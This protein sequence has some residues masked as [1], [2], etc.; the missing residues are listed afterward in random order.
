MTVAEDAERGVTRLLSARLRQLGLHDVARL[1]LHRNQTV[2]VSLTARGELRVHEG[3]AEA[4]DRVLQAIVRFVRPG[5]WRITRRAALAVIRSWPVPSTPATVERMVR[6]PRVA[7]G[8]QPIVDRLQARW[9]EF[10][11]LHF[12]DALH[13]IP[14]VISSRMRRMLGELRHDRATGRALRITL[15]RRLLRRHPWAEVE[16]TLLHEMVHQWQAET[17]QPVGHG[18]GFRRKA[19]EVGVTP[20][21]VAGGQG[22]V[23]AA[24]CSPR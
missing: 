21:A 23:L 16:E 10:N 11:A 2:L 15:S 13:P 24:A 8:D 12:G 17:G 6:L 3:Y 18:T 7:P 1:R 22:G 9:A 4:P 5:A 19:R 14:I 20:R